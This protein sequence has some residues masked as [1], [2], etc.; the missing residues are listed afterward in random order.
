MM[1]LHTKESPAISTRKRCTVMFL[2]AFVSIVPLAML[3]LLAGCVA[4]QTVSYGGASSQLAVVAEGRFIHP[5]IW[6][7]AAPEEG[8]IVMERELASFGD[9]GW[10]WPIQLGNIEND[11]GIWKG[12]ATKDG[13]TI[14]MHLTYTRISRA[15]QNSATGDE[16]WTVYKLT[17]VQLRSFPSGYQLHSF[18][19]DESLAGPQDMPLTFA[20]CSITG[21]LYHVSLTQMKEDWLSR[22]I[23]SKHSVISLIQQENQLFQITDGA[24]IPCAEFTVGKKDVRYRI[25]GTKE[26]LRVWPIIAMMVVLVEECR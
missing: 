13:A 24:G 6:R 23:G 15:Q 19:A 21:Q 9:G 16:V 26:N 22:T 3:C 17:D 25:Y 8:D 7:A 11:W 12:T 1:P 20:T 10:L 4:S 2:I 14:P 18:S 5:T